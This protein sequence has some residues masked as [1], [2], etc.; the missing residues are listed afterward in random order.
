VG[1]V[2]LALD[3]ALVGAFVLDWRRARGSR[4]AAARSWPPLLVQGDEA[5]VEVAFEAEG[6]LSIQARETLHPGLAL[7]PLRTRLSLA[8]GESRWRYTLAPR[9]RGSH[10]LGPLTVRVLGP[11]GLAWSQRELLGPEPR[12]VYPQVRWEGA[13]GRL[14]A[15]ARRHELGQA[16]QRDQGLGSEPYALR[17]YRPGDPPTRIHWK[18]TARHGRPISR[19]DAW[20]RGARLVILIDAA[21]AMMSL[22]RGRSKL[23]HALAAAL[24]LGRVAAARGDRVTLVAFSDRIERLVRMRGGGRGVARAYGAL[25]DVE[26]RL[27]EP[28]YDLAAEAAN[29]SETRR[30]SVVLLTSIVDLAAAELLKDALLGLRRHRVLLVNLEDPDLAR[31]ALASPETPEAAFAKAAALEIQLA[32]RRLG[33]RLQHRGI[34]VVGA[35]ADRLAWETLQG[36]L[37]LRPASARP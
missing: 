6:A 19:E 33:R 11:W 9:R 22:D 8:P 25:Y 24:A 7:G 36:Y 32:N 1:A 17:E 34:R 3:I 10:V 15:L 5:R 16:P 12:R 37:R 13:V 4:L 31:L 23:D 30:A 20:E 27:A 26:A 21:R 28:A 18:A 35:P 29:A 2:A 14:L